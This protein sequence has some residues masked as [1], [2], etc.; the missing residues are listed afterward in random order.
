LVPCRE[1]FGCDDVITEYQVYP[2]GA[3][4]MLVV[5]PNDEDAAASGST[6]SLVDKEIIGFY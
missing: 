3:A 5:I 6:G 1:G 4:V 2:S